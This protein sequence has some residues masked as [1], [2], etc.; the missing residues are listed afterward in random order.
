[1]IVSIDIDHNNEHIIP[2]D[3]GFQIKINNF[4]FK[5]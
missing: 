1:M 5:C 4:K 2:F 3:A